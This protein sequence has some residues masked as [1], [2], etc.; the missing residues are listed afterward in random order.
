MPILIEKHC[1][2]APA[3]EDGTRILVM[4]RWPRGVRKDRFHTWDRHLGPSDALLNSF[5]NL[6]DSL[7]EGSEVGPGNPA[8][9]GLMA[10]YVEEMRDQRESI[11]DLRRRHEAGEVITLLCTCHE[12]SRCH[13]TVLAGLILDP[14]RYG[15]PL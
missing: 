13:R 7:P 4:R 6:L 15:S 12:P 9:D 8:W 10:R 5:L 11:Q 14:D 2:M 1:R 3:P